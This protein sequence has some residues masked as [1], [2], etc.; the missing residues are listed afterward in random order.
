MTGFPLKRP[1]LLFSA[2]LLCSF[3]FTGCGNSPFGRD[4]RNKMI[5]SVRDQKM[6]LVR[7]GEPV[8][9]YR[10]STSKFGLGDRPGSNCTPTGRM[11]VAR[12]SRMAPTQIASDET[13]V[14][15]ARLDSSDF[16]ARAREIVDAAEPAIAILLRKLESEARLS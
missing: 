2:A 3:G 8:K 6:L 1:L 9:S 5:V 16:A 10:I 7:D 14:A 13:L 12:K 4:T 15:L 11:Q